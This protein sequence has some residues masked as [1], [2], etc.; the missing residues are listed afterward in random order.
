MGRGSNVNE[1][2]GRRGKGEKPRAFLVEVRQLQSCDS[3]W[4]TS[5][6]C[7]NCEVQNWNLH[8]SSL[9]DSGTHVPVELKELQCQFST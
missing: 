1:E 9:T 8:Y 5:R 3:S 4:L 6:T 7:L 2:N